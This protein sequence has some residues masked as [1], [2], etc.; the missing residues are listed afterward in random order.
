MTSLDVDNE[1]DDVEEKIR[2]GVL[3]NCEEYQKDL[4]R[5]LTINAL[6]K[7]SEVIRIA[8]KYRLIKKGE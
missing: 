2:S 6:L 5:L 3:D 1:I 8:E 7:N 4:L